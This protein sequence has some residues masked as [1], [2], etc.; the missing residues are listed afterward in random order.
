MHTISS[1]RKTLG[2]ATTNQV[3]NR[4]D[5]IRDVLAPHLRRGPNNQLLVSDDG[6]SLLRQLQELCDS[7][8]RMAEA[9]DIMRVKTDNIGISSDSVSSGS[10]S[11]RAQPQDG[12]Q[13]LVRSL[14]DEI[15]FLRHR[16][17]T[18]EDLLSHET[19][20]SEEPTAPPWW[21]RLGEDIDVA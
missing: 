19:G 3:R 15:S 9:S 2:L 13:R 20:R 11:L 1:L 21:S 14:Q 7:G 17:A 6:V 12:S 8:L 4:I 16:V 18:L 5:S 10:G